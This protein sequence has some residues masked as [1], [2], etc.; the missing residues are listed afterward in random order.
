MT[1]YNYYGSPG[2]GH[3]LGPGAPPTAVVDTL[4]LQTAVQQ[5]D[6]V[7]IEPLTIYHL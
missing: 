7:L 5:A 4:E 6:R 1:S 2:G 3:S